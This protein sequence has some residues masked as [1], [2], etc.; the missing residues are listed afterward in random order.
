M[1]V[2]LRVSDASESISDDTAAQVLRIAQETLN[3]VE[4]HAG[5]RRVDV[6]LAPGNGCLTLTIEDDGRGFDA[7][8]I[9]A[10]ERFGLTGMRERAELI[11]AE[12]AVESRMGAGTSVRL[13]LPL[14]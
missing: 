5:A 7:A 14:R 10:E 12:F 11:G 13:V 1:Q 3:N 2:D 6:R 9:D 4:R 8:S